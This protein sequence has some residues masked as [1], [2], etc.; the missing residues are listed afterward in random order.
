MANCPLFRQPSLP[1]HL[2]TLTPELVM[3]PLETGDI[4]K[5]FIELLSQVHPQENPSCST[6]PAVLVASGFHAAR[7]RGI[8]RRRGEEFLP[9]LMTEMRGSAGRVPM[10]R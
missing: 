9:L 2:T 3:R 4:D 6:P 7:R 5:G 10:R 8:P 1:H